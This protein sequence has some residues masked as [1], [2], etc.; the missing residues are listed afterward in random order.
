MDWRPLDRWATIATIALYAAAAISVIILL[1]EILLP[2]GSPAQRA[3]HDTANHLNRLGEIGGGA[4]VVVILLVLLGGGCYMLILK[5]IDKY[6][7]NRRRRAQENTEWRAEGHAAGRAEGRAEGRKE[8]RAEIRDR[9]RERGIDLD[10][11]LPPE[12]EPTDGERWLFP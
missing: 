12:E 10:D 8:G 9:L 6:H 5:A 4:I 11:L 1:G 7:E 3:F 2:E